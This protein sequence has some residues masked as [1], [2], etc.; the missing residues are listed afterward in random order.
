MSDLHDDTQFD[1]VILLDE[2]RP[3]ARVAAD[4]PLDEALAALSSSL[5]PASLVPHVRERGGGFELT[6]RGALWVYF[7][8]SP[9]MFEPAAR[10]TH[11]RFQAHVVAAVRDDLS[12]PEATRRTLIDVVAAVGDADGIEQAVREGRATV[13]NAI[14]DA[15][16]SVSK[17]PLPHES[18][19]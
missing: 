9:T 1:N 8:S 11:R 13:A 2:Y 12:R 17:R 5:D 4:D 15:V 14:R 7:V 18:P 10:L 3:G 19:V 16:A 6:V